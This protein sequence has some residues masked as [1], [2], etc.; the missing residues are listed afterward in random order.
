MQIWGE[1]TYADLSVGEQIKIWPIPAK[2][3]EMNSNLTQNP[4]WQD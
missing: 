3:R 1:T 2:E 4:G